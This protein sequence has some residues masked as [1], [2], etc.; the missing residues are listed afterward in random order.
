MTTLAQPTTEPALRV[1]G[2][3]LA[4][5]AG[6]RMGNR[7]KCLLQLNGMSLLERQLQALSLAGVRPVG[8]VLGHHVERI[9][10][11]GV[12]SRWAAQQV[13][14][15]RPDDGHVSSL[16][17]GLKAMPAELDMVVVALADQPLIDV[18]AVQALLAAFAQRPAGTQMLQPSVQ[19]L[20][21]NP[22]VFS[23]AVMAQIL[24]G[25]E[26][27]G[28]RQWQQAHPEAVYHWETPH[29]HYRL[30]VDNETDCQAVAQ[31]TGQSLHWPHDLD[32]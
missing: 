4:A 27:M 25:D 14:N 9:L 5:G 20:P 24:A 7:P 12:L 21:G 18:Q 15:P 10:Q 28:A 22:V 32:P 31:L 11:E 2:L 3:V 26:H 1:G 23:G 30:D 6:S 29:G 16:R 8:V 19:G 17:I 13:R